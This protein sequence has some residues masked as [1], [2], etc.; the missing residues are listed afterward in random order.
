MLYWLKP[1]CSYPV[2][3]SQF[4]SMRVFAL[5]AFLFLVWF[6][7]DL[8]YY[9]SVANPLCFP[10]CILVSTPYLMLYSYRGRYIPSSC[11]TYNN[12]SAASSNFCWN[13][14]CTWCRVSSWAYSL[15]WTQVLFWT[16]HFM[17][18]ALSWVVW[19]V[20]S[21]LGF[22]SRDWTLDLLPASSLFQISVCSATA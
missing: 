21:W 20:I 8:L 5:T 22:Q 17:Y 13:F 11:S 12:K 14:E 19:G 16:Q 3:F 4:A 10:V 7:L 6:V 18:W 1:V 2:S 15:C 9:S